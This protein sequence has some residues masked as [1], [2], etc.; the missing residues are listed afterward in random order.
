VHDS[1]GLPL[2]W[3]RDNLGGRLEE[4]VDF[5]VFSESLKSVYETMHQPK[6]Y[7]IVSKPKKALP[8]LCGV[9]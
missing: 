5:E 7:G 9:K 8:L 4:A 2:Q 6:D 1:C 3:L